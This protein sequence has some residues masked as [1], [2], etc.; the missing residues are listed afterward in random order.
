MT[1]IIMFIRR[2]TRVVRHFMPVMLVL[3]TAVPTHAGEF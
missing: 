3:M 1:G 2:I